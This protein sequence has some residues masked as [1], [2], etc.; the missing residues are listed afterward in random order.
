MTQTR[1]SRTA[2]TALRGII[3]P[4]VTPLAERNALDV[5][6]L[7]RLIEHLLGGGIH[8]LF[9]LGT[10]GEGPSLSY[11]VRRELIERS[12]RQV[13]G[14]VP[15]LVG[16]TDTAL[17]E[18]I[19]L[20]HFAAGAGASAVVV[21][22]PCYFPASQ[23]DLFYY[24]ESLARELTLPLVLYNMPSHTKLNF[25]L[26]T[27][28]RALSIPNI[29]GLKDSSGNMIY[30]Q[31]V[32]KLL[33]EHSKW[34]LLIG[35]EELLAESVLLGGNGGVSGGANIYPRLYVSLYEAARDGNLERIRELQATVE[36]I[37]G[38]I[39][40]ICAPPAGVVRGHQVCP[41]LSGHL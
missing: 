36:Q 2:L 31:Q 27:L 32:R 3:P 6:G 1:E 19:E 12:C 24:L 4:M 22:P 35:P 39:Y 13:A 26:G 8:G 41:R 34:S 7:E 14:R 15:V 30:Y 10:T 33:A 38:T 23:D 17:T 11:R 5:A 18:S 29:V 37:S 16:I 28:K 9:I 25:D 40:N 21:A 20:A